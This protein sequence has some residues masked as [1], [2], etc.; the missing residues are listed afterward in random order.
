MSTE[1]TNELQTQSSASVAQT[2]SHQ[3]KLQK[4]ESGYSSSP[5]WYDV[6]G[7]FILKLAYR[8][9]LISQIRFFA[10]NMGVQHL[11]VA[12]G[13]G[14][15]FDLILKWR[16]V[17]GSPRSTI[18]A[19]DYAPKMLEGAIAKFKNKKQMS[20]EQADVTA[21]RYETNTF[22]TVNIANCLHCFPNIQLA[23][24]EIHRVLK[25]GGT[26]AG[27]ILIYPKGTSLLD[28]VATRINTWALKKG[29]LYSP[30]HTEDVQT[31][32]RNAG[33]EIESEN[34]SGNCY[35][36]IARKATVKSQA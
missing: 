27:N 32:L 31:L 6:R 20:L 24:S 7:F 12:I 4:I 13:T 23:L 25:E 36:F 14:T 35:N 3:Q 1:T 9:S 2:A 33:F 17:K 5:W 16:A 19:F 21:M 26:M 22:D 11:E 18:T 29:I 34:T 15:L 30:Y 10:N 28:R 8:S